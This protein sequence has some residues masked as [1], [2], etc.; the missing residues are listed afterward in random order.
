MQGV[1][2]AEVPTEAA[3]AEPARELGLLSIV[4]PVFNEEKTVEE[5][6]RRVTAAIHGIEFEL[7][8]VDDGS[9]DATPRI[10]ARLAAGDPRVRVITLSRNFGHQARSPRVSITFAATLS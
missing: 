10:L 3:G 2:D 8:L 7:V 9:G 6:H 1:E 5:L 4:A